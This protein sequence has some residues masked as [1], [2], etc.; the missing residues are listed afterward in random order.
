MALVV[1]CQ[2]HTKTLA[3]PSVPGRGFQSDRLTLSRPRQARFPVSSQSCQSSQST[4]GWPGLYDDGRGSEEVGGRA[5]LIGPFFPH[6]LGQGLSC[7]IPGRH[8]IWRPSHRGP[9]ASTRYRYACSDP[10]SAGPS[11]AIGIFIREAEP[12]PV[13]LLVSGTVRSVPTIS[14]CADRTCAPTCLPRR[15]SVFLSAP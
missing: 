15:F 14:L 9:I 1:W 6:H 4:Q 10:M 3:R 12:A 2:P 5:R 13:L 8:S 11:F 7:A